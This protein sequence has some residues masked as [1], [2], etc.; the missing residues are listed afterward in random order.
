MPGLGGGCRSSNMRGAFLVISYF[1]N[2]QGE[3]V[4]MGFLGRLF[5]RKK[6]E[7]KR[8]EPPRAAVGVKPDFPLGENIISD[9]D[10]RTF[11]DLARHYSLPAGLS[12][13]EGEQG[14]PAIVRAEDGARFTFLIEAG[15]LTFNEPHTREDG[16]IGYKTTEVI[17]RSLR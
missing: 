4:D 7:Q 9:G 8:A 10:I 15:M 3:C 2:L 16:R 6:A 17:K 14:I 13:R 1:S 12:Y 5:G 11:G